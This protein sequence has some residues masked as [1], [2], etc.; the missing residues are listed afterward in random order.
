M[1]HIPTPPNTAGIGS[2]FTFR[3]ETALP[4]LM[5]AQTLLR[6]DSPL[7]EGERELIAAFV[8]SRNKCEFC[9]KSHAATAWH[10]S[11]NTRELVEAVL[12]NPETASISDKMKALLTIASK[13]QQ[14]GKFVTEGD[15]AHARTLG[16]ND[17]EIH[18]TV[19][20]AA[21]FCMYNRYVDGLEALTPNDDELY[22][23]MG[24]HLAEHGY[25]RG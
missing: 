6:G 11:G 12:H 15:I 18:D 5:L 23:R 19:L 13:V 16:A 8:S 14:S 22:D 21:A 2:L 4:M 20:I 9:T 7:T 1:P 17:I 10:L 25:G 24:K 3:K